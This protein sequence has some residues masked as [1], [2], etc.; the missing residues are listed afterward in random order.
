MDELTRLQSEPRGELIGVFRRIWQE[1]SAS[2]L[3]PEV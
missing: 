3:K 1:G 2:E